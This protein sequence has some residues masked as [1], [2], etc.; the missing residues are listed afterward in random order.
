MPGLSTSQAEI[1]RRQWGAN[2]LA[3]EVELPAWRRFLAQFQDALVW[4]LLA[5]AVVSALAWMSE[6]DTQWPY[7]SLVIVAI[8]W[9]NASLGYVQEGRAQ[10]ALAALRLLSAPEASVVRDGAERRLPT[11][12]LV[13]GDLLVLHEGDTVAADAEL[14]AVAELQTLESSL[15][16]ES[17]PVPKT[18]EPTAAGAGLADRGNMV[19]AGTSVSQGHGRAIVTATGMHTEVGK[20]A[21]LLRR[22]PPQKTP[23]QQEL[24]R[25]G[26]QLGVVVLVIAAV[27]VITLLGVSGVRD[28]PSVTRTLLF[29]V[30]LA[31][32]AA[33]E[34]LA[35]V[36]TVV[37]AL[38]VQRMAQRGAI[39]RRLPAV[40]TLGSATVIASDKTGTLTR[41]EMTVRV[42]VTASGTANVSGTGYSPEGRVEGGNRQEVEALLL[43]AALANNAHLRQQDG[44]WTIQGDPTEA[45]LLV[46]ARKAGLD[47]VELA[48][49][50]PRLSEMTFTSERK[51]MST[52]HRQGDRCMLFAKGSPGR[53]LERCTSEQVE[54]GE[55]RLSAGRREAIL[56][57]ADALAGQALRTL[58]VACRQ[59][60]S[61]EEGEENLT[62]LGLIAMQD[63]PRPEARQAIVQARAAGIRPVMIT[64]DHPVTALAIARELGIGDG[65][66]LTGEQLNAMSDEALA[67]QVRVVSVYARVDPPHK[68]RIVQALQRGG[69]IVAMTG[70]GVNDA[71][72]LQAADIGIAMG[73]AG[74]D[75]ARQ[76]ADLILTDDNFATIV[77]AVAEGRAVFQNIRKFLI[78][79]LSSNAG[80]V[81]M[82]FLAIAFAGP[83]GLGPKGSL[84][85]PLLASQ[86]LWINLLTDGGP[87]LALGV[88]PS[89]PHAMSRPPRPRREGAINRSMLVGILLMGITM[90][91]SGIWIWR[92]ALPNGTDYA[93][94]MV[95]TTLIL[96][97]TFNAFNARSLVL[98]AGRGLFENPWLWGAVALALSLQG[99]VIYVPSLQA[100][101][102]TVP[103]TAGDWGR[104]L[105]AASS[106]LWVAEAA[107]WL[108]RT[109]RGDA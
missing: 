1:L 102:G 61:G 30:A 97:Q 55:R 31:V 34:G 21:G 24:N 93:R 70:D 54:A 8:V 9:L 86:I 72:A 75:V 76:A 92:I 106:A 57:A 73:L 14:V 87:A 52:V 41:N 45:A 10:K 71:P 104:S 89:D 107:K 88:D 2:E 18:L 98:S 85:L 19:F 74:T 17:G 5:A 49:S 84:I 53:L 82:V 78:Y 28:W 77:A 12:E 69:E 83:L 16:G 38:G 26:R 13:P 46:A 6:R 103:L 67:T 64:G 33:P 66:V 80:E 42:I 27:V 29:G 68:L 99:L 101:F 25:L 7:E 44:V 109:R 37:L 35:G 40:E 63:P 79:L 43:A 51:R 60:A 100:A 95:F 32:A 36:V 96:F 39:V 15:T 90:A 22:V 58:G 91:V 56:R 48:A 4:L 105:L 81:L 62:F 47:P 65:S 20:I 59:L 3:S 11:R 50:L 108:A 94:T 23:L